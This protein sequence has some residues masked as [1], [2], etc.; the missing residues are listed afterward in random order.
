MNGWPEHWPNPAETEGVAMDPSRAGAIGD[1]M[2]ERAVTPH[3][4]VTV[5][6]VDLCLS[7][8]GAEAVAFLRWLADHL[9]AHPPT[10]DEGGAEPVN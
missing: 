8:Q 7:D 1:F 6:A 4:L 3:E 5:A 9:Q 10:L 2:A